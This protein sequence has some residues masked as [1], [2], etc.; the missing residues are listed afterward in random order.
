MGFRRDEQ[1][2][3]GTVELVNLK[4]VRAL[5]HRPICRSFAEVVIAG[6]SMGLL[7]SRPSLRCV[8]STRLRSKFALFEPRERG[9]AC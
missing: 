7:E 5:F 2:L 8:E 4:L 9:T 1:N 3:C 6:V